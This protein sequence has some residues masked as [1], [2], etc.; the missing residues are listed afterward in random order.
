MKKNI[1]FSSFLMLLILLT[2][3]VNALPT[4]PLWIHDSSG[5]LGTYDIAT[6]TV[7]VIGDMNV[8]MTDI[9]FNSSGQL[10]GISFTDLYSI[11]TTDAIATYIGGHGVSGGNALVF[12]SDGNL[13]AA[14]GSTTNLYSLNTL[15]GVGTLLGNIGYNSSGDLAFYD[16]GFYLATNTEPTD[17][18][19][20]IDQTTY[21]GTGIGS[22]GYNSVFG[23]ATGDDGV[24]Y[25][26]SGVDVFSVDVLTGA[27]TFVANYA[28]DRLG[29]SY[30]S[31]F[32]IEPAPVPEPSTMF[33]LGVGIVS[34]ALYGRKRKKV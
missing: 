30:G 10:Y 31:S 7:N 25:G 21:A 14:G 32:I 33:L 28:D 12:G 3:A 22:F 16:G 6:D 23:L 11:N 5:T 26:V 27:G 4:S 8:T 19:V 34:L 2:T 13:Y 15:T 29:S 20:S 18:L 17:T 9:A 1:F 24:L